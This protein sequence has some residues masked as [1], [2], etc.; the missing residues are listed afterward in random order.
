MANVKYNGDGVRAFGRWMKKGDVWEGI[1]EEEAAL[2]LR[3]PEFERTDAAP[4]PT[5]LQDVPKGN[6][7]PEGATAPA[8]PKTSKPKAANPKPSK[9]K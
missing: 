8:P 3:H 7:V 4:A 5:P 2:L 1:T 6:D 9:K